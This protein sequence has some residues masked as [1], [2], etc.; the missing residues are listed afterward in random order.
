[1]L[2]I[3]S[4]QQPWT[5]EVSTWHAATPLQT[6]CPG[7]LSYRIWSCRVPRRIP[8][9]PTVYPTI[10]SKRQLYWSKLQA[11]ILLFAKCYPAAGI[12]SRNTKPKASLIHFSISGQWISQVE[13]QSSGQEIEVVSAEISSPL[14][15]VRPKP[16]LKGLVLV[17]PISSLLRGPRSLFVLKPQQGVSSVKCL[18]LFYFRCIFYFYYLFCF[19]WWMHC[20][21]LTPI[22]HLSE[23]WVPATITP[24]IP[25]SLGRAHPAELLPSWDRSWRQRNTQRNIQLWTDKHNFADKQSS[26]E[27]KWIQDTEMSVGRGLLFTSPIPPRTQERDFCAIP[28]VILTIYLC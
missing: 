11:P 17:D 23:R 2:L 8:A 28:H 22:N 6:Y 10:S 24:S 18:C 19:C 15:Q 25:S 12:A 1:M 3:E 20:E 4:H 26:K 16:R 7:K 5:P 9:F 13:L 21:F 14:I 27:T